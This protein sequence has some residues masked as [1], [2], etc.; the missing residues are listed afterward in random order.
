MSSATVIKLI[1]AFLMGALAVLAVYE[2]ANDPRLVKSTAVGILR[3]V[4]YSEI[5]GPSMNG[6]LTAGAK[7]FLSPVPPALDDAARTG[8]LLES[9]LRVKPRRM[10]MSAVRQLFIQSDESAHRRHRR[11]APGGDIPWA[12]HHM[13]VAR[14]IALRSQRM[15]NQQP[16]D[17]VRKLQEMKGI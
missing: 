6:M 5:G 12:L 13:P 14:R 3:R 7:L 9:R 8:R 4:P 15:P 10:T 11:H 16:W 17:T 2:L 1:F